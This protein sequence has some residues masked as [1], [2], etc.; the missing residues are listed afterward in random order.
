MLVQSKIKELFDNPNTVFVFDVDGVL[1]SIEYGEYNHYYYDDEEWAEDLNSHDFYQDIR[2]IKT[3]QE[4]LK[5]KK[6]ERV[7]VVTKVMNETEKKYK[8]RFLEQH[9][10]ID[11]TH[12]FSVLTNPDKLTRM[13]EIHQ[14][15]PTLEDK[16]MVMIDDTV[17]VLNHIMENS[18]YS[19][20]H[21]SSFLD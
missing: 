14:S 15:F 7:Y 17:D 18:N 11:P 16:Y 21:I 13:Q 12:V 19:T 9:Y 8:Q 10:H 4:F 3:M 2:T 20:V 5:D 6:M 1:A